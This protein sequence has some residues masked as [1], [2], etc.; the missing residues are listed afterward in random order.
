MISIG[1]S[2]SIHIEMARRRVIESLSLSLHGNSILRLEMCY[3]DS[4]HFS[5]SRRQTACQLS[6]DHRISEA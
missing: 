4:R 2:E 6:R 5:F 3:S 1:K